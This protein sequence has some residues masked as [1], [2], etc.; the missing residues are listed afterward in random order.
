MN[1]LPNLLL[2]RVLHV[3]RPLVRLLVRH[4][5]TYPA[6]A[7][8]LKR[9]FLQ[10]A[11][12]E[13][14]A[15]GKPAS[16]SALTLMSGVHRRDVRTLL[17]GPD[18]TAAGAGLTG[19]HT[20]P[21][22]GLA[23][24]VVARWLGDPQFQGPDGR[25]RS[26]ARADEGVAA[27]G[28][29]ALVAAVSSDVRPRAVLDELQRLGVVQADGES[30]RVQLNEAAF[31]PRQGFEAMAAL[32]AHNLHDHAAAAAANLLGERNALE[33][34]LFVDGLSPASTAV[35]QKAAVQAW[36]QALREVL[37]LA[38]RLHSQDQAAAASPDT[39]AEALAAPNA[40][41]RARFGVYFFS[42]PENRP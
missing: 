26:L 28:F 20:P 35:L 22:L 13:L 39:T 27:P 42:E 7:S 41:H 6:L 3:L 24:E 19:D 31:V 4:G 10:A 18:G 30:S 23:S 1:A 15:Q 5:V 21:A 38:Q 33:Q 11:Q 40:P 36:A 32:F 12:Q 8:A 16:D 25:P 34:A 9:V 37:P 29:D 14:Q 17:R 2:D